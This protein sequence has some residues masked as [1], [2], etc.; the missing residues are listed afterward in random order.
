MK[1]CPENLTKANKSIFIGVFL[2]ALCT[3][4]YELLLTRIFSVT[5]YYHFSFLALSIAMFGISVGGMLVFAYEKWFEKQNIFS[6]S[7]LCAIGFA[8]SSVLAMLLHINIRLIQ[9]GQLIP[10]NVAATYTSISLPF[11]FGG[12]LLSFIFTR[13]AAQ[14]NELYA[15][16]L[17]GASLGCLGILWTL[18]I[19]DGISAVLLVSLLAALCGLIFSIAAKSKRLISSCSVVLVCLAIALAVNA[20]SYFDQNPLMRILWA[21]GTRVSCPLY[22]RWN[23]FSWIAVSG[24]PASSVYVSA[25]ISKVFH[26]KQRIRGLNLDIDGSA[27]TN[28][29]GWDPVL[30]NLAVFKYDIT[31]LAYYL[32]PS[33][34]VLIIGAGGG[35]DLISALVFDAKHVTGIEINENTLNAV[36]KR[37]GDFTGHL[38][39]NAKV[40]FINDEAR[41]YISRHN[42]HYDIIQMPFIDTWAA[43]TNGAY[44]LTEASLYTVEA[45]KVFLSHLTD[46]GIFTVSR[47][48]THKGRGEILRLV[49]LTAQALKQMGVANPRT[50]IVLVRNMSVSDPDAVGVGTLLVCNQPFSTSDLKEILEI[51]K[52]YQFDIVV[53]PDFAEDDLIGKI[54]SGEDFNAVAAT[55]PINILPPTD[56][57]PFFFN[58]LKPS[59]LFDA[60]LKSYLYDA[61]MAAVMV[62][63]CVLVISIALTYLCIYLPIKFTN[64]VITSKASAP[65]ACFFLLIGITYMFVEISLIQRLI[66]FLGH[67]VYGISVVVFFLLLSSGL[68]SYF[69]KRFG[70]LF[71]E[72]F[73]PRLIPIIVALAVIGCLIPVTITAFSQSETMV[74]I[75]LSAT[76]VCAAGFFMGMAF[77]VGLTVAT[78]D[79]EQMVPWYWG[80]N[81]AGSVTGSVLAVLISLNWG[82][83]LLYWAAI[84]GYAGALGAL[85]CAEKK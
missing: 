17:I 52:R 39:Q 15:V 47:W 13:Y 73:W 71:Q 42:K 20:K 30:S 79:D 69:S 33:P 56:D 38:D 28:L 81:G 66:V 48:Y 55:M 21:K 9:D 70:L 27:R 45:W 35:K 29:I 36:N 23:S 37:F 74:R 40:S 80:I 14:F 67:P 1:Q 62:L 50:H 31:N 34:N 65:L 77:P 10:L 4:M 72:K 2:I 49:G 18:S 61:N 51:A 32:F 41:S 58:M 85:A 75:M 3:L 43:T 11:L 46:H 54:A 22:E 57:S 26:S 5:M 83:G 59:H 44:V 53:S 6:V 24:D 64:T 82:I 8:L 12:I 60:N 63:V 84:A 68:G 19:F 76:L 16:D 78:R 7:S 25:A